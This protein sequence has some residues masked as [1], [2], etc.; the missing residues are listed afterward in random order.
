MFVHPNSQPTKHVNSTFP[1]NYLSRPL[2][3]RLRCSPSPSPSTRVL[4]FRFHPFPH[5]SPTV[6]ILKHIPFQS[7]DF[8]ECGLSYTSIRGVSPPFLHSFTFLNSSHYF[9][10]S[11]LPSKVRKIGFVTILLQQNGTIIPNLKS[12]IRKSTFSCRR[13]VQ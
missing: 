10:K 13:T 3:F 9:R 11:V 8:N 1:R 4:T 5:L 2:T 12:N 7:F 6:N